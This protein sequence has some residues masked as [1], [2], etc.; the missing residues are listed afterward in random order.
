MG[1]YD[2]ACVTAGANTLPQLVPEL[3][4][5]CFFKHGPSTKCPARS[6]FL[7][8]TMAAGLGSACSQNI[9]TY[10]FL[11]P[12]GTA[13]APQL[14]LLFAGSS[15]RDYYEIVELLVYQNENPPK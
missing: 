10:D 11:S 12:T 14:A 3:I 13:T 7:L 4:N 6:N 15:I 9:C 2:D 8:P 5:T 1:C